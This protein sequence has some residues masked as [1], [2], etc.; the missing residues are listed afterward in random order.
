[1][2]EIEIKYTSLLGSA[3]IIKQMIE[4]VEESPKD[5]VTKEYLLEWLNDCLTRTQQESAIAQTEMIFEEANV[6]DLPYLSS[7]KKRKP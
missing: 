2:T 5:F 6:E 1:M 7:L 4:K 3:A